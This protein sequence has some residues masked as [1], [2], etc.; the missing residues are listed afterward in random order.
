MKNF[1]FNV[2]KVKGEISIK[3]LLQRPINCKA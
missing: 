1:V 3:L 2:I